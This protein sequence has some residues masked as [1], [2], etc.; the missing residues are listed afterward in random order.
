MSGPVPNG[1]VPGSTGANAKDSA[2]VD[3]VPV[4]HVRDVNHFYGEGEASKQVL[5]RQ[6]LEIMPGEI[7]IMTGPSGSGKTTLLTLIGALRTLQE[8]SIQ[9]LGKELMGLANRDLVRVRSGIGFIFQAHNLFE[10]LT[11]YQNVRMALELHNRD[12]RQMHTRITQL[13]GALGLEH[14]IHYKPD[15][16]S[17]GQRQRVA[18]ARALAHRPRLILADEPTAALDEK[19]GRDVVNLLQTMAREDG[20]TSVIVTHDNRILD[21]ADRIVNMV[22]GR[23]KKNTLVKELVQLCE[24]LRKCAAF[25]ALTPQALAEVAEKMIK[26]RYPAGTAIVREGDPGD[27]FFLIR[28]GTVD[29]IADHGKPSQRQLRRMGPGEFFGERALMEG[30][31]RSATVVASERVYCYTLGQEEFQTALQA[32][33]SFHDQLRQVLFSRQ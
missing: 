18:I 3:E 28:Q 6:S 10:S 31:P 19:S 9:V 30:K 24:F 15:S 16:L 7:V 12:A 17:G 29:V 25:S 14:R 2:V 32:S 8:G 27:T 1:T 21:V 4:I 20:V 5:F 22:D 11:A 23:I 33:A 26:V 13:L